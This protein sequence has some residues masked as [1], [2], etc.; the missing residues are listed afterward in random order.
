MCNDVRKH[1]SKA[2]P[3]KPEFQTSNICIVHVVHSTMYRKGFPCDTSGEAQDALT[4]EEGARIQLSAGHPSAHKE[5]SHRAL[6]WN[7]SAP[8]QITCITSVEIKR[9]LYAVI[10]SI[11]PQSQQQIR[12]T[13]PVINPE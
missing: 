11:L 3:K 12:P 2:Y 8:I 13:K 1:G 7:Y 9:K 10:W 4:S 6:R 5:P